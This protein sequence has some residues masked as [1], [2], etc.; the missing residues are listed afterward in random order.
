M[1]KSTLARTLLVAL[2]AALFAGCAEPTKTVVYQPQSGA[3]GTTVVVSHPTQ[4]P[5]MPTETI[6]QPPDTDYVWV[7]GA[8]EWHDSRW[9][10][11]PGHWEHPNPGHEWV[12]GHWER[13]QGGYIWVSPH[14][15]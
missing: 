6:P 14:W 4:P 7:R 8:W 15:E 9:V 11:E 12:P 13:T 3:T 1:K 5:P 2:G 10:W